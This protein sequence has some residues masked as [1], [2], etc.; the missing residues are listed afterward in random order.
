MPNELAKDAPASIISVIERAAL[1]PD[2][3][4]E[5]LERLLELQERI[6][7]REAAAAY[8][9]ALSQMQPNLPAIEQRGKGHGTIRYARW[10]DIQKEIVPVLA[11]YD[12]ALSFRTSVE[13]GSIIVTAILS[14]KDGHSEQT[15]LPLPSDTTGSKNNVQAV[16]SSVSYG[17]RYTATALLN[18]NVAGEDDD[19]GMAGGGELIS[20]EMADEINA[21]LEE[22]KA[23]IP[24]FLKMLKVGQVENMSMAQ[25]ATAKSKLLLKKK[26][27]AEK[28]S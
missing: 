16:G 28:A 9:L 12:F 2:I 13:D 4:I 22:T 7:V 6:I 20:E 24:A 15:S 5:K 8:N 11:E 21:M 26:Q 25:Y 19:G 14:H 1:N 10:E 17:K 18:L 3:D 23:N 27:Q